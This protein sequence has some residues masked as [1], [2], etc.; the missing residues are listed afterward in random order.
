MKI[1]M[2]QV[3][4]GAR[5]ALRFGFVRYGGLTST[6]MVDSIRDETADDLRA[7]LEFLVE[8]ADARLQEVAR[9][10]RS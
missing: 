10:L 3:G 4:T 5:H 8:R 7:A 9:V 6:V 2:V 1:E